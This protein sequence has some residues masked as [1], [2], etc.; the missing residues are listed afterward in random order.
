M[1]NFPIP[2]YAGGQAVTSLQGLG[3]K[4]V[5]RVPFNK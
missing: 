4:V 5:M 2:E 3:Y 1:V